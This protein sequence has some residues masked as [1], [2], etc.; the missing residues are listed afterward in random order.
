MHPEN[1]ERAF[2]HAVEL[3]FT[4]LETDVHVT[5]DGVAIAFHDRALDRVTDR[6]GVISELSWD[7]VRRARVGGTD[8]ILRLDDLLTSFPDTRFNLDPKHDAAVEPLV[9][10]LERTA[11][12]ERVCVTSFSGRRTRRVKALVGE[13]LCTGGGPVDVVTNLLAGWRLPARGPRVEVLQ[14]P[15][16][17]G[18]V[19]VVTE[20]FVRAAHRRNLHVH[21]WTIDDPVEIDRLLD[22]G[23]DGIMTDEPEVL[24]DVFVARGLWSG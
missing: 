24:R 23:V 4:H 6:E 22:L 7:E 15:T 14:V 18:R 19:P 2:R 16:H 3:G 20:R 13:S 10:V 5:A 12:V 21:V 9:D 8:E 11:S 1:T 17:S